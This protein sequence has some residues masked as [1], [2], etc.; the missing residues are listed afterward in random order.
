MIGK[1]TARP[2]AGATSGRSTG[3]GGRR[4]CHPTAAMGGERTFT[5]KMLP[6]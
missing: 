3:V 4:R 6:M 2:A 1:R 5:V